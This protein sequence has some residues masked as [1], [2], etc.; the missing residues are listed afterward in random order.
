MGVPIPL[1]SGKGN[2]KGNFARCAAARREGLDALRVYVWMSV[3][4]LKTRELV[5]RLSSNLQDSSVAPRGW[6]KAQKVKVGILG[7]GPQ[8][9]VSW[10]VG[11]ASTWLLVRDF[12]GRIFPS[13][14]LNEFLY[15]SVFMWAYKWDYLQFQ[16]SSRCPKDRFRRRM[17]VMGR[18]QKIV[19]FRLSRERSA[20]LHCRQIGDL[21]LDTQAQ[22]K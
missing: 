8:L 13:C 22:T 5:G 21:A 11:Y 2:L 9:I 15:V 16:G 10:P 6:F 7:W 4:P 12:R 19:V 14:A 3:C 18:G 1:R 17:G 20:K